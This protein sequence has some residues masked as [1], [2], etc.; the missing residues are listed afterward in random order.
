MPAVLTPNL[1]QQP[2]EFYDA[3]GRFR[4]SNPQTVFD[5]KMITNNQPL[6]WNDSQTSGA[7]TSSTFNANQASVTLAVSAATAGTRVR[8][9]YQSFNYQPGK[10]Q[11][12]METG[13]LGTPATGITRRL[14]LF[15]AN[16][17]LFF[18]SSPTTVRVVTRTFT[19]GV[20]VDNAVAQA[21]WNIDPLDGTGPSGITADWSKVQ[22]FGAFFEWLGT[23]S[24][25]FFVV[26]GGEMILVHRFDTANTGAL[27]YMSTPNLPLRYEISNSGAGGAANMLQICST[28]ISEGGRPNVGFSRSVNRGATALTTNNNTSLYPLIAV[29]LGSSFFG[30]LVEFLALGIVC[31]STSAY[32]WQLILNPTVTGTALSFTAITNSV[33]EADVGTTNATTVSGGTVLAGGT[34]IQTNE[35]GLTGLPPS[36]FRLGASIAGVADIIVLAVQRVTG[37]S[38]SFYA[39]LNWKET[40]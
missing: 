26:I 30:S 13:I 25:W 20:A 38:E 15:N 35:G 1:T 36:D 18:E 27:V 19:S 39:S 3:F 8:Q 11:L 14:G 29:R 10:S 4:V 28:V 31:T 17:G 2:R 32:N 24:A 6:I 12:F 7:G 5:S 9:T 40:Q 16:N 33:L 34:L 23:G 22:I 21:S 37:T